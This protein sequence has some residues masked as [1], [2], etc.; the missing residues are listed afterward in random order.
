MATT[1]PSKESLL[2]PSQ[3]EDSYE[4]R[5]SA[6]YASEA[7]AAEFTQSDRLTSESHPSHHARSSQARHRRWVRY[8]CC[9]FPSF[10]RKCVL[11]CLGVFALLWII[12]VSGGFFAYKNYTSPP[13][14]LSP[15][16]YPTPRGGTAERW[17]DSY[18]KAADMVSRMILPE[19]VNVTTGTGWSMGLAVGNT[20]PA[21]RVGFPA[22]A[23]QDGPL[24]NRFAD[25]STAFPA[26]VTVGATWNRDLM[27]QWGNAHAVE[28]RKK[29]INAILGPCVGPLGRAPAGGRN[30]EG[31]GADPYL[32]GVAAAESIRGIQDEGVMATIKHFVANE[33]E[34]YRQSWEWG[35]PNALSSNVDDRTMHELYLWPFAD[36]VKAGVASVMCSYNMVNNSYACGNSKLLNGLLR[37]ELGFQGFVMS[38]WLAQRSGVASAL[39]G[40]DMTMP[41]DGLFWADGK[42]LWG[43]ELT[44]S[45]LNGSVPV[46]R[47]NDMVTRIVAAWYQLGQ[48]DETKFD[49]KGP[50]FSSWTYDEEGLIAPGS[51]TDQEKVK[52]NQYVDAMGNHSSIA[53]QIAAE[54][55]VLLKN[56]DL[57]P[58]TRDGQ[59]GAA[60]KQ[61]AGTLQIAIFGEDAGPGNGPN[62]CKDAGCNQG[63]LAEGWG[64]GAVDFPYLVPPVDALLEGWRNGSDSSSSARVNVSTYLTND[65][66]IAKQPHLLEKADLCIVFANSDSGEG[67]IKWDSVTGDRPDLSLQKGG[68]DLIVKVVNGCGGGKG[69]VLVVIHN[70]GPVTVEKWIDHPNVKAVLLANLPGQES[71]NALAD[72]IFG[73]VSPSGRLP[74]TIG[75]G[76]ADYGEGGQVMYVPNGIVPQ[77]DFNEGLYIDY[78]HFD[79]YNVTPRFEFGYGLGYTTFS[80]HNLVVTPLR[81]KS[82]FPA[83]RPDPFAAPPEYDASVP[84]PDEV[85]FPPDLRRLEKYVYP[86]LDR[87]DDI[88]SAPYPYPD[89]YDVEQPPSAAGGGEGG[90]PD[91]WETYVSVSVDVA[92]T[93]DRA[94]QA[95]PQ[96][97]L[98][99][100]QPAKKNDGDDEQEEVDFP[101]RVLRGFEKIA[102]EPAESRTVTFELT[103]RDLSYWD[104]GAQNWAMLEEG[105]YTF[106]VGESSRRLAV[107]G[108]W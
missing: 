35:L 19:K 41:G 100:P 80:I 99:Y 94:G 8:C 13:D 56:N 77:Q 47:L 103:R 53:R 87:V 66:P 78:R 81:P 25:N 18:R 57:L 85:L 36:A 54:G 46:E 69:D 9:C 38:D 86:Y 106:S 33:Q 59:I 74:W 79:K 43:P 88:G 91:L 39:A 62:Y 21:T 82:A 92:N 49:R 20:G 61:R 52:V 65:P 31:F 4:P 3:F 42:S 89:G 17:A 102:L 27:Y 67:F 76:L 22:L 15:P 104:V 44:R 84:S 58:I 75:K 48:D 24:G 34:H 68:D 12:L 83:P 95:V 50:N 98:S 60:K 10:S 90:N 93:G 97:Y 29:G 55:T 45:I 23:L 64:S 32:Q 26:G 16:W 11:S 1:D 40:L 105:A 101:V 71:G 2:S 51:P 96:L 30:W 28:A 6:E 73:D 5:D 37:D 70:V 107:N 108:T 7:D 14:G 63:T 72:I